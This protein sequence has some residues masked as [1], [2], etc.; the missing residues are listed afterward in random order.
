MQKRS[1]HTE[2]YHCARRDLQPLPPARHLVHTDQETSEQVPQP[3]EE[4]RQHI[5]Q[6]EISCDVHTHDAI[7]DHQVECAVNDEQVPAVQS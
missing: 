3:I 4:T 1:K 2:L 5:G 7:E 6:T